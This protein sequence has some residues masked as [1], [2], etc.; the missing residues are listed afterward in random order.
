MKPYSVSTKGWPAKDNN[1]T[2][3]NERYVVLSMLQ[4]EGTA[5]STSLAALALG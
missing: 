5:T 1:L 4:E 3:Y 2:D